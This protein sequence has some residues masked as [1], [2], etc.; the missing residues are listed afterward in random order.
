M[1]FNPCLSCGVCCAHFRVSFYWAETDP[2][3]GGQVPVELTENINDRF[4]CMQG[5]NCQ[6]PRCI[7]LK[8]EIGEQVYCSIYDNRPTPCR[9]YPLWMQDGSINP[10]CQRLRALYG[11][12]PVDP[13]FNPN[14][15]PPNIP[16]VA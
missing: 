14:H 4:V 3:L 13:P 6:S 9:D 8:G 10:E 16:I 12:P 5:T 2:F 7:A 15:V 11:L 1:E